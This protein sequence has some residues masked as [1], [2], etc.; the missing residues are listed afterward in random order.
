MKKNVKSHI[1]TI[2]V[3]G[4]LAAIGFVLDRF[5]GVTIPLFG[6]RSLSVNIS[7][8]PIFLAGFLYGPVWGALVGGVQDLLCVVL[9]PLGP[10]IPGITLSTMLAGAMAGFF[11]MIFMRNGTLFDSKEIRET[12]S[13]SGK[14]F[15]CISVLTVA[16]YCVF[17]F[18][19]S[20]SFTFADGTSSSLSAWQALVGTDE[21]KTVFISV[22]NSFDS[23]DS[24][25]LIYK[26][27]AV[28]DLASLV[29]FGF[30]A[31]AILG[32]IS[33]IA[34][35]SRRTVVAVS[36]A[37]IGFISCGLA[38]FTVI[39][40][41]PK[42]LAETDISVSV[43]VFPYLM[44]V[45]MC[46][47]LLCVITRF[48]PSITKLALFC[49]IASMVTSVLNSF[50]ISLAYTSVTFWVYLVPRL[51]AAVFIGVPLYTAIL[52]LI[53]KKGVPAL[54]KSNLI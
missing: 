48:G 21:Y 23:G 45:M 13:R 42:K 34:L 9:V 10:F 14:V 30:V 18:Q 51:A 15:S 16:A 27:I 11:K 50:W 52:W 32:L 43:S 38:S 25:S 22:L 29:S 35:L 20:V 54:K 40:H 39:L 28:S 1:K 37:F 33:V 12:E 53:L 47:L 36:S 24:A 41:I 44:S 8:V 7:Y 46:L 3:C 19:P 2:I 4:I 5:L 31:S 26:G 49:L 17:L 6:V